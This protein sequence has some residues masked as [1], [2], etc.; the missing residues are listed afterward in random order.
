MFGPDPNLDIEGVG[1]YLN[2]NALELVLAIII[3]NKQGWLTTFV[4]LLREFQPQCK[5]CNRFSLSQEIF[6]LLI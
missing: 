1:K 5:C 4:I 2:M 3:V 6:I